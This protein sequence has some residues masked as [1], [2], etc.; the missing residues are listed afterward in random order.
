MARST[1]LARRR[2]LTASLVLGFSLALASCGGSSD[3]VEK[4]DPAT[5]SSENGDSTTGS[6]DSGGSDEAQGKILESGFGQDGQYVYP[7]TLV[8]NTSDHAGQTVVVSWNF[9]DAAGETVKTESQTNSFN[10]PG[11]TIAVTTQVDVGKRTQIASIEPTLLVKD[12]DL[13]DETEVDFGTADATV[14]KGEYGGWGVSFPVKNPTS[15]PLESPAIGIVCRSAQGKINGA[16]FTFPDLVP[17]N[18]EITA[19]SDVT[20]S[21]TPRSCKAYIAGP[22]F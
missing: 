3:T 2:G 9:L 20:V 11:Q 18:G 13:F 17:P 15:A 16:G 7:V 21:G 4:G 19:D 1:T 22:V 10:F 14:K 5:G 6:N 8:E 12:D